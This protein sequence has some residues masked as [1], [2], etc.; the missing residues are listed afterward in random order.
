MAA[1]PSGPDGENGTGGTGGTGT[2]ASPEPEAPGR[3]QIF[4]TVVDTFLEKLVE[5]G[6]YPRFAH[7]YQGFSSLR[8]EV[9]RSLHR[10]FLTQLQ[11]CIRE[12]IQEVKTE[13]N[14]ELLF[15]SL[16][17]IVEEAKDQE[18]PAWRPS[19]IP[20][21]DIQSSLIPYLLKHRAFL[22]KF[23]KEKEE[24]NRN[25]AGMVLAGRER[26]AEL[27]EL[28]RARRNS[29]Q[30]LGKEREELLGMFRKIPGMPQGVS[31]PSP[32]IHPFP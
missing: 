8:P 30:D 7:C 11:S 24:E 28:I 26:I 17:K 12:E 31:A 23:L 27:R 5:A 9:L 4:A 15:N 13:G 32:G 16:D 29:W 22:R 2:G 25:I 20:E 3:S 19:G 1:A 21:E 10:Q 14:L 6:S 18:E